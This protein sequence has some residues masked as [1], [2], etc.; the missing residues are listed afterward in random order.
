MTTLN[1]SVDPE[2]VKAELLRFLTERVKAPVAPEDDLFAAGLVSS[3]F[4]MQLVVHLEDT[5]DIEIVGPDLTMDSFRSVAAMTA[6]VHRLGGASADSD[7]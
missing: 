6:L 2:S 7:G 3:M 5:Y 4:A 1:T